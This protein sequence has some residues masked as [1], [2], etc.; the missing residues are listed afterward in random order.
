MTDKEIF[1]N[2]VNKTNSCWL[3]T[4]PISTNGYGLFC[5][6]SKITRAHRFSFTISKGEIPK[7]KIICHKCDIPLCVNPDHLWLGTHA[8]NTA[9]KMKKGRFVNSNMQKQ[10]CCRGHEFTQENTYINKGKRFCW[11][12]K[13]KAKIREIR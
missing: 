6:N 8:D 10:F 3:W 1:W 12:C 4:G 13:R 5:F 9:D 11:T 2:S 7:D